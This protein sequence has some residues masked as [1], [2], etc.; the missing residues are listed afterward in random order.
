MR[1]CV[2]IL[3]WVGGVKIYSFWIL[4]HVH[5]CIVG[6]FLVIREMLF[7]LVAIDLYVHI[8]EDLY[9]IIYELG[10]A[11]EDA[12]CDLYKLYS[13]KLS[14]SDYW[15]ML[16]K[17]IRWFISPTHDRIKCGLSLEIHFRCWF[18]KRSFLRW[19]H[20]FQ[21][22]FILIKLIY[23]EK[24]TYTHS[25]NNWRKSQGLLWFSATFEMPSFTTVLNQTLFNLCF[26]I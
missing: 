22:S 16:N 15:V 13:R 23:S 20:V 3:S 26:Y 24:H 21:S 12:D 17:C 25:S 8:S 2:G 14:R 1:G 4:L 18:F 5:S 19:I 9:N 10:N 7:K 6:Y 11:F